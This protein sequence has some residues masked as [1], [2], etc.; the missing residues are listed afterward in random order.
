M[1]LAPP[2][3]PCFS[4]SQERST[5]GPLPYQAANT[6]S[7]FGSGSSPTCCVPRTAAAAKSSFTPGWK[8]I[9]AASSRFRTDHK[10]VSTLPSGEPK[11]TGHKF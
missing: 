9:P 11:M 2:T 7:Y 4:A 6:P 8:R 10:A 1:G 3:L 5:P